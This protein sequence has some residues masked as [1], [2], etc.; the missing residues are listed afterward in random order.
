MRSQDEI[1]ETRSGLASDMSELISRQHMINLATRVVNI[2]D[3]QRRLITHF[4]LCVFLNELDFE[5]GI[6]YKTKLSLWDEDMKPTLDSFLWAD[7]TARWRMNSLLQDERTQ[8][9]NYQ[10]AFVHVLENEMPDILTRALMVGGTEGRP[11]DPAVAQGS[12]TL[13]LRGPDQS[14]VTI[15]GRRLPA[16]G[17]AAPSSGKG[18]E[19]GPGLATPTKKQLRD[20]ARREGK[21]KGSG[22]KTRQGQQ[23]QQGTPGEYGSSGVSKKR[24]ERAQ[25][26]NE[27]WAGEDGDKG[28]GRGSPYGQ[29]GK[30]KGKYGKNDR[31]KNGGR[32]AQIIVPPNEAEWFN[33]LSM[34]GRCRF[35]NSSVG[36][37]RNPCQF[38]HECFVCASTAH[39]AAAAHPHNTPVQGGGSRGGASNVL[40]GGR[41]GG[42]GGGGGGGAGGAA[43]A[44][45][46]RPAPV[47]GGAEAQ[48]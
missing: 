21:G 30:G 15:D 23:G 27:N 9:P 20:Q 2:A 48:G 37:N 17:L 13:N 18:A 35:F 40:G 46:A 19:D 36:C 26:V 12:A 33:S 22:R 4:V 5:I 31:G 1:V 41:G 42:G 45:A 6:R 24:R 44:A 38:F 39:G 43:A 32:L 3:V 28:G 34:R 8:Y 7:M 16:T 14:T 25:R 29:Q 47:P 11:L 10:A